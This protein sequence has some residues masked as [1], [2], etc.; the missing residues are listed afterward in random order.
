MVYK[1]DSYKPQEL[2][3]FS[4]LLN[5]NLIDVLFDILVHY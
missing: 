1:T 4:K 5:M 3:D 2:I